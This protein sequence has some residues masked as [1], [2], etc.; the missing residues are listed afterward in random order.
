M[1]GQEM[2]ENLKM[3]L[4]RAMIYMESGEAVIELEDMVKSLSSRENTEEEQILPEK[5]TLA[6][7]MDEYEKTI[8]ETALRENDGNKSLTANRLRYFTAIT[9][10]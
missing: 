1:I 8:L 4:S 10:L 9:L 7:I 2:S 6:S 3:Y 5:S